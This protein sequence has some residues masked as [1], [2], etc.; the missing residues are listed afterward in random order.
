MI[1]ILVAAIG[2]LVIAATV[3]LVIT[4]VRANSSD[5]NNKGNNKG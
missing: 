3:I 4:K 1:Y 5:N 2:T